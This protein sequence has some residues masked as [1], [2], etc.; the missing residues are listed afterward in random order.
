MWFELVIA[1]D[2]LVQVSGV[3]MLILQR[4]E[5]TVP[6]NVVVKPRPVSEKA[7]SPGAKF[8]FFSPLEILTQKCI[9]EEPHI[10]GIVTTLVS[11]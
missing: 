3:W 1:W 4:F 5:R 10:T 11:I 6:P 7:L 9:L 8:C 2:L